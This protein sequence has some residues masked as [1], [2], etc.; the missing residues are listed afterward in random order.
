[1]NHFFR[2]LWAAVLLAGLCLAGCAAN[3]RVTRQVTLLEQKTEDL[4][5][6][7]DRLNQRIDDL[8][9]QMSL[10][11]RKLSARAPA[12]TLP[13]LQVVKMR[14]A[15]RREQAPVLKTPWPALRGRPMPEIDPY[16][17]DERLPVEDE[18]ELHPDRMNR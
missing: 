10:M 11:S 6:A 13:S 8:Q 1:M 4:Q 7:Q 16:Q 9:I 2:T 18:G 14:P 12:E 15:G 17:V 5:R 3:E